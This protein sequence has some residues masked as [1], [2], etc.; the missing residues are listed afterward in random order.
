[1]NR[2]RLI[3]QG[4]QT[5]SSIS[6]SLIFF[7]TWQTNL[8]ALPLDWKVLHGHCHISTLIQNVTYRD[9]LWVRHFADVCVDA[10]LVKMWLKGAKRVRQK[11]T[12]KIWD[13]L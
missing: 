1:M 12:L 3:H 2:R 8:G 4:I 6:S 13:P 5:S 7:G 11:T 10:G 9:E